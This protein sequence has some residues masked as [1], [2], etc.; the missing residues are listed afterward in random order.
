MKKALIIFLLSVFLFAFNLIG[1]FTISGNSKGF[2]NGTKIYLEKPDDKKGFIIVDSTQINAGKFSFKGAAPEPSVHFIT[3]RGIKEKLAFILE[4]G[5]ITVSVDKDSIVKGKVT[6]TKNN[7]DLHNF[8]TKALLIQDKLLSFQELNT[9]KMT[10]AKAANDTIVINQLIKE[11]TALQSKLTS[12]PVDFLSFNPKSFVSVLLVD[13][14]FNDPSNS[15]EQIKTAYNSL[16]ISLKNTTLGKSIYNK[17]Q[18][19]SAFEI[20]GKVPDFSAPNPEGKIISLKQSLGKVTIIDFWASWC[21]PCR[22]ENPNVVAVY[23]EFKDK[24][25][26]IIGVSLDKDGDKWKEAIAKD[27]LTWIHVSNLQFW[28]DPIA[29]LYNIKSIPATFI[30]DANGVIV[31]KNVRGS[32]LRRKIST[33]LK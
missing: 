33:L 20:G 27:N 31:A 18:K 11:F 32:D 19:V 30:V 17:T 13:A 8:K 24:G 23:K 25:L 26:T 10:D 4:E 2:E 6:G 29:T 5:K 7:E 22:Q 14:M 9:K 3:I 16:D 1:K 21:G 15:V 28:Q 12:L